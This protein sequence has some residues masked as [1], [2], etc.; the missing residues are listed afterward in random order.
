MVTDQ[1]EV[2]VLLAPGDLVDADV[3]Q[4]LEPVGVELVLGD[5]LDDPPDGAPVDPHQPTDRALVRPGG[6]VGDE[7]LEVPGEVR[8]RPGERHALGANP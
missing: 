2:A 1:G 3:E 8:A 5:A 4:V 6:Q 7:T